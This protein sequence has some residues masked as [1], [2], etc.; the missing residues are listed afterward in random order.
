MPQDP[1]LPDTVI[2]GAYDGLKNTVAPERMGPKDLQKAINID[3]DDSGQPR[4]RRGYELAL[5]GVVVALK[6]R[7]CLC[8]QTLGSSAP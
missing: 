4:R 7:Y 6:F 1:N 5:D 3:L 2:V 8:W